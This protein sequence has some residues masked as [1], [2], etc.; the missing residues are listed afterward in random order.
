MNEIDRANLSDQ[1][2]F[3]LAEIKKNKTILTQTLIKEKYTVKKLSK[4][5][6]TFNYVDKTLIFLNS[7][8][9]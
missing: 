7:T 1:T 6:S 4:Y 3:I 9:E 5:V 2:K 8:T